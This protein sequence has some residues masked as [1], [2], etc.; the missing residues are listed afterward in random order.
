MWDG[1]LHVKPPTRRRPNCRRFI[2][3]RTGADKNTRIWCHD[4]WSWIS[5]NPVN[6]EIAEVWPQIPAI[7]RDIRVQTEFAMRG[8]PSKMADI[9]K[10][11][12]QP[13]SV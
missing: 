11:Q 7:S 2:P 6:G 1:V 4:G 9:G 12:A 5:G 13:I 10:Y 8:A 3:A